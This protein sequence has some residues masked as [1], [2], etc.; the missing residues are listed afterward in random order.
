MGHI[1]TIRLR[2]R[3]PNGKAIIMDRRPLIAA[4][5]FTVAC[6]SGKTRPAGT[7]GQAGGG[8]GG[9]AGAGAGGTAGGGTGGQGGAGAGGMGAGGAGAAGGTGGRGG[10]GGSAGAGAGGQGGSAGMGAGGVGG[11]AGTGAGG[12]GGSAGVGGVGGG[13]P[14]PP[15]G[16]SVLQRN[17]NPNRDGHYVQPRI[18]RANAA[19]FRL[20]TGFRATFNGTMLAAPLYVDNGPG[21]KGVFFAVTLQNDVYALDETTGAVVWMRNIGTPASVNGPMAQCGNV[22]PLGTLATPVIDAAS[23]TMFVAAAV[24]NASQILRHELHALS[25]DDGSERPGWPVDVSQAGNFNPQ[26]YNPRSALS[27]VNGIIYVAYGGHLGD[28]GGYFGRV[29]AIDSKDPTKFGQWVSGGVQTG[30]WAAGGMPSD[31]TGVFAVTGNGASGPGNAH[32]DSEQLMRIRGMGTLTRG[33][34]DVFFPTTWRQMDVDDADFGSSSPIVIDVAGANPQTMVVAPS[35]PGRIYFLDA[36]RLGGMGGQLVDLDATIRGTD[37]F[38][39]APTSYK[40]PRGTFVALTG[41]GLRC[42]APFPSDRNSRAAMGILVK[43]GAP[44]VPEITWCAGSG[45]TSPISTT[46]DGTNESLVWYMTGSQLFARDGETGAS[47]YNSGNDICEFPPDW[48][49]PIAVK[50]RIIV[51]ARTKLCAYSM[52]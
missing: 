35:K 8:A 33:V 5:L 17:R 47:V 40:T 3:Y 46:T 41:L 15:G 43:P 30:I 32:L 20:E 45:N 14:P 50:G 44:A 25:I 52:P 38:F 27:L 9:T 10:Q 1:D 12:M 6:A 16:D 11:S 42:P 23:R 24:G 28:C 4:L 36:K 22:R 51:N 48:A 7:G 18:T 21:G 13:L 34:E 2:A 19:K 26:A 37:V 29:V 31:G 49:S 39:T